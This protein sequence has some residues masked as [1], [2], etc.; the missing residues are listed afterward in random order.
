MSCRSSPGGATPTT[1][2]FLPWISTCL[3]TIDASD[4]NVRRQIA[5]DSTTTG[6]AFGRS[7]SG[8]NGVPSRGRTPRTSNMFAVTNTA[9]T[10]SGW[11]PSLTLTGFSRYA[12]MSLY[13]FERSRS[14]RYSGGD[15]QNLSKPSDGNWL[16]IYLSLIHIS[17]PTRLLSISYAVF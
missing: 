12:A 3:P 9:L 7:C 16:V 11:D 4:P 6:S 14:S 15:T 17:E 10:R 1:I 8:V 5:S 13:D 2:R